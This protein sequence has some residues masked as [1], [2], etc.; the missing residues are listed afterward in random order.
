MNGAHVPRMPPERAPGRAGAAARRARAGRIACAAGFA[1]VVMLPWSPASHAAD[2][3][4]E[5]LLF[6]VS[7]PGLPAS[8]VFGTV[9]LADPRVLDLAAPVRGAFASA[10][11]YAAELGADT[12]VDPRLEDAELL[13][14][15][16]SLASMVGEP[17]FND[18]A[19]RLVAQGVPEATVDRLKPWVAMLSVSRRA[20]PT[21]VTTLDTHLLGLARA[22]R[23]RIV[24]LEWVDEQIAAFDGIPMDT[25][26]ALLRHAVANRDALDA[27]G[28]AA[29]DAWLRRDLSAIARLSDE[30]GRRYPAMARHYRILAQHIIT[31]RTVLMHHRLVLPLREGRLFIAVGASHLPGEKGLLRMLERDGYSVTRV[32]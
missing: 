11:A 29:L 32:W 23:M 28:E 21:D 24:S 14:A 15:G 16:T 5:G 4:S 27:G 6:R 30:A 31:N 9:H 22:R 25:Q 8:F 1:V 17:G 7:K 12:L 13:P 10:R 2:R 26:V 18:L 19:T 20:G 3:F